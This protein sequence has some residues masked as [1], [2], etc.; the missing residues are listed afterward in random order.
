MKPSISQWRSSVLAGIKKESYLKKDRILTN[1]IFLNGIHFFCRTSQ[2]RSSVLVGIKK[3][4]YLS[5]ERILTNR[6]F[7]NGLLEFLKGYISCFF[8][9]CIPKRIHFFSV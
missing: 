4:S 1:R 8:F 3:E 7:R 9:V 2:W 5:R 6:I